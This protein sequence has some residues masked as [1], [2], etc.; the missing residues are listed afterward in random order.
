MHFLNVHRVVWKWTCIV[1]GILGSTAALCGDFDELIESAHVPG[2]SIA[3]IRNGAIAA[4]ITVGKRDL[5]IG[6][7]VEPDTIFEAASLSKPVFAYAVLQLVDGGILSLDTPLSTY[8]PDYVSADPRAASITVRNV[9]THTTGLP[10]L[11]WLRIGPLKTHFQ[12]GERFSYSGEAFVWLQQVVEKVTGE[13]L[14]SLM[15][16]LVFNPLEMRHSSYVWRPQFE[17]NYATPYDAT[18]FDTKSASSKQKP[19]KANAAF[20]LHTTAHDYACFLKAVLSGAR[21]KPAT[22]KLWLEPAVRLKQHCIECIDAGMPSSDQHIAWGL[23]WGLEPDQGTFFHWG[24]N[25]EFKAFVAGSVTKRTAVVVFANGANGMAVMPDMMHKL[26][27]GDHPVFKWLNYPEAT[28]TLAQ[29]I[30]NM[31]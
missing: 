6:A 22:A 21:L 31:F 24:D 2:L 29:R 13:D 16:R 28:T 30:R 8:V 18:F 25:G 26:A 10:N 19:T 12:P 15:T 9:L 5:A 1:F 27:P 4:P 23:G 11:T 20:S 3:V 7:P 14:D 17:A